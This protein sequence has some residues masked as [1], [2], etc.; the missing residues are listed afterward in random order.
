M[1]I[2]IG[3]LRKP[4][5]FDVVNLIK[6]VRKKDADEIMAFVGKTIE[7]GINETPGLYDNSIVWAIGGKVACIS[8]TTPLGNDNWILWMLATDEF[9]KNRKAAKIRSVEVFAKLIEGKKYLFNYVWVEHKKALK[10]VKW[11]GCRVGK[12]EPIGVNGE[13]FCKIE[14]GNV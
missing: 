3:E 9:D 10:W 13:L 5:V 6:N 2:D 1:S 14:V 8:G 7:E 12:P 4:T 11:L